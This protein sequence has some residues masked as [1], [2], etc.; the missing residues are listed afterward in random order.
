MG[1]PAVLYRKETGKEKENTMD[2]RL[3]AMDLDGTLLME[4]HMHISGRNLAALRSASDR[5]IR[6]AIASGRTYAGLSDTIA[7]LTFADYALISNGAAAVDVKT[8]ETLFYE[9]IPYEK[10]IQ[11]Y[12]IMK[13]YHILFEI[14]ANGKSYMEREYFDCYENDMLS[15]EFVE[16]LKARILP[17]EDGK[18]ALCGRSVE[19][20]CSLA[21]DPVN[22][23]KALAE[24]ERLGG[25]A[26]TS[27]I[28]GN[29]EI[30]RENT[31][32]GN[33]LRALCRRLGI[34]PEQVMAFG[35][36]GNDLEMLSFAGWSFAMGNATE[37]ARAAAKYV[38]GTNARDG[39]AQ[40]VEAAQ[41]GE[42]L[43]FCRRGTAGK[44]IDK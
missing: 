19:K 26:F 34:G 7:Q 13:K 3:I 37:E 40:A 28:P 2:I 39:V 32:K 5:G 43:D 38:T 25:L 9:G 41:S 11:V 1:C 8:K 21:T 30:N 42:L 14:Y 6:L 23:P 35:D 10:W 29:L 27:S 22:A 20:I 15:R 36:A 24:L 17:V 16:R 12:D 31:N 44:S 18:K 33:A 4:D